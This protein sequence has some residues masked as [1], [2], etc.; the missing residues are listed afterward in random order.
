MFF[1]DFFA[2]FDPHLFDDLRRHLHEGR[3][4]A[5]G[6]P[7]SGSELQSLN[8]IKNCIAKIVQNPRN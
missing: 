8:D 4:Y 7:K 6:F 1:K 5:I 3:K 2:L